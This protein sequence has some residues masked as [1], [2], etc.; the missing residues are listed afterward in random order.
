V[1][2]Q[3]EHISA[4]EE[5]KILLTHKKDSQLFLANIFWSYSDLELKGSKKMIEQSLHPTKSFNVYQLSLACIRSRPYSRRANL[6]PMQDLCP[7]MKVI[8][9]AHTPGAARTLGGS[10]FN[11]LSGLQGI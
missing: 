6:N 5:R 11:H 7:A 3:L 8:R 10:S 2:C 1:K 9:L 4:I